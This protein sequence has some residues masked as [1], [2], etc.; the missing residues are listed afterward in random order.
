MPLLT[1]KYAA[2]TIDRKRNILE[3]IDEKHLPKTD[4]A[5]KFEINKSPLFTML[6]NVN[7]IFNAVANRMLI[8]LKISTIR[9]EDFYTG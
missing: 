9:K 4:T 2:L 1:V 8:N 6:K 7:C 5:K 3:Y